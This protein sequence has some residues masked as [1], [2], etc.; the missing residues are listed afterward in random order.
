MYEN[1]EMTISPYWDVE[2][3][4]VAGSF[5]E[6]TDTVARTIDE[7]VKAHKI[8]D[9]KV[10]SFLSGGVDSSY[11]TAE[12]MPDETFSVGFHYE[13]DPNFD[14]SC[15]ARELSEKLGVK[16]YTK[17]LTAK[18]CMDAVPIIQYHMDEPQSNPSSV[19]SLF[20]RTAC[21]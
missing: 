6:W 14:E 18:E 20:S 21:P 13:E 9:V 5:E 16:N 4:K 17:M 8:S 15:Y 10:G 2:Y 19:P 7:S 1:G 3:G 11:I 12:L